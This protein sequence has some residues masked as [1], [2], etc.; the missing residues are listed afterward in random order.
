MTSDQLAKAISIA[1]TLLLGN[2]CM[3]VANSILVVRGH[4]RGA[5]MFLVAKIAKSL[6]ESAKVSCRPGIPNPGSNVASPSVFGKP[7]GNSAEAKRP[8]V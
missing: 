3:F 5:P 2:F 6:G 1:A 7:C 8:H 4:S